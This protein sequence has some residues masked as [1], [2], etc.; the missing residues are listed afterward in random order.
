MAH[1]FG[2]KRK[3]DT[4]NILL[5]GMSGAGK[6]SIFNMNG[7][8]LSDKESQIMGSHVSI[9]VNPNPSNS[10]TSTEFV[11]HKAK[12]QNYKIYCYDIDHSHPPKRGRL[13]VKNYDALI[14]VIDSKDRV[15][16]GNINI[17][18]LFSGWIRKEFEQIT[19]QL[20]P[21][22]VIGLCYDY[23]NSDLC[24][25]IGQY[26]TAFN[27]LESLEVGE[28]V[29]SS[30]IKSTAPV[31]IIGDLLGHMHSAEITKKLNMNS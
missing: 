5:T 24:P 26:Q 30:R 28:E 2:C 10:G 12:Y 25:L 21:E 29:C 8:G 22:D 13:E 20:V 19:K 18:I 6:K 16:L 9:T 11:I 23:F 15:K 3:S 31:L 4:G 1:V 7:S 14:F 17:F 27:I